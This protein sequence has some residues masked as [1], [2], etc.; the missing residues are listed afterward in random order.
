MN[1]V[2]DDELFDEILGRINHHDVRDDIG[3]RL[4]CLP[5]RHASGKRKVIWH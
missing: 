4:E 3:Y 5:R 1:A 2:T